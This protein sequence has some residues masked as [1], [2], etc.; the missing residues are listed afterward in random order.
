MLVTKTFMS[1]AD[2][3]KW[4]RLV[5]LGPMRCTDEDWQWVRE[6]CMDVRDLVFD[7]SVLTIE[8]DLLM[9]IFKGHVEASPTD[10]LLTEQEMAV[11]LGAVKKEMVT[12]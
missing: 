1:R 8:R 3:I 10:E 9:L 5:S 12:A 11:L 7:K 6:H 2:Y 4:S